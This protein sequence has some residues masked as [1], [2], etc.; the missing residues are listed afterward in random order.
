MGKQPR[1]PS[2]GEGELLALNLATFLRWKDQV[3][4]LT[5][6]SCAGGGGLTAERAG[7]VRR[8]RTYRRESQRGTI[9][10][11]IDAGNKQK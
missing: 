4:S 10:R 7:P 8:D 5:P 11:G 2:L 3:M 9:R 6:T 1:L